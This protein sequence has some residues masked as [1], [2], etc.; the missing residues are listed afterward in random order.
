M[1]EKQKCVAMRVQGRP[2]SARAESLVRSDMAG[3]EAWGALEIEIFPGR[4]ST[5]LLARPASGVYIT[6]EALRV[7][8][9][10]RE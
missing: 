9:R 6:K 3:Q 7:L 5:L 8:L 10:Y 4:E 1:S 2:D